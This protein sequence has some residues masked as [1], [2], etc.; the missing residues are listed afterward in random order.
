MFEASPSLM[1]RHTPIHAVDPSE[2]Q[3]LVEELSKSPNENAYLLGLIQ[4]YSL[5]DLLR[6]PWGRFFWFEKGGRIEGI[7]YS[8]VTGVLVV[9]E[10][11]Q[12][13]LSLFSEFVVEEGLF[14][15]RII[16]AKRFVLPFHELLSRHEARWQNVVQSF[17]EDA[18]VLERVNMRSG[19]EPKLRFAQPH[20]AHRVAIG[21]A[22]AMT[23]EL[24]IQTEGEE[25]ERLVRSKVDLIQRKRYFVFEEEGSIRFQAYLSASLPRV[26]QVQGV[27]VP[28]EFRNEGI[29][30]RC[31]AEM[32]RR[33]LE[34]SD[35]LV[36]RV[37]KRNLPAQRV[38][39]KIGFE[40]FLDCLSLWFS[41]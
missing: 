14:V 36:L 25:F 40:P 28:P 22:A 27:W 37:Q 13:S 2:E 26:G 4:D 20:E 41:K 34:T 29:A 35:R 3:R 7:F 8:D 10:G 21:S 31:M 38:Y 33:C 16:A 9:S 39:H 32:C 24:E 5:Y 30:T 19:I 23:E 12:E 15:N 11:T 1:N 18:M 6:M 17:E